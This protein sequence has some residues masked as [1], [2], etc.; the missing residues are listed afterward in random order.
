MTT[1]TA[2]DYRARAQAIRAIAND[3][4]VAVTASQDGQ[5]V[6]VLTRFPAGDRNAYMMAEAAC[7][8]VLAEFAQV[9][10]G[11]LWGTTSDSVG[12]ASGLAG[13]YCRL[14]KSGVERRLAWQFLGTDPELLLSVAGAAR[15]HDEGAPA[16]PGLRS[17]PPT[18]AT[19]WQS[20][21]SWTRP[22]T[23]C[24]TWPG[25]LQERASE[26]GEALTGRGGCAAELARDIATLAARIKTLLAVTP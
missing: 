4:H 21:P 26:L 18:C 9:R 17:T 10:G 20:W 22:T 11:S 23:T 14:N 19:C 5:V 7:H 15:A 3:A 25:R 24:R 6:T 8:E 13:G 12:G 2:A 1:T 16:R